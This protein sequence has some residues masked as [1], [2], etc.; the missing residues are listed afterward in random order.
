MFRVTG[1]HV[2]Q[3]RRYI[4]FRALPDRKQNGVSRLKSDWRDNY[5]Q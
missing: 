4:P 5:R 2:V 1:F 3:K